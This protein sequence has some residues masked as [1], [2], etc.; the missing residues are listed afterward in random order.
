LI[1]GATGSADRLAERWFCADAKQPSRITSGAAT[2]EHASVV[3]EFCVSAIWSVAAGENS[4]SVVTRSAFAGFRWHSAQKSQAV[5]GTGRELLA[6]EIAAISF[7]ERRDAL[8]FSSA[9]L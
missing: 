4:I 9:L 5:S 2:P 7:F 3:L 8:R 6:H 1:D